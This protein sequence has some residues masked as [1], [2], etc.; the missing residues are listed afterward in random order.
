M[1]NQR[2]AGALNDAMTRILVLGGTTEAREFAGLLADRAD[3]VP[4]LSLAGRTRNPAVQ[5]VPTRVGGFGGTDGL[6]AF[7]RDENIGVLV[8]ATH[9]YA[10]R[11][12]A[13]AAAAARTANIAI[14]AIRRPG[15]Q[16]QEGDCWLRVPSV[17]DAVV[18]L[19]PDPRRVFLALGRN[20]VRAFD[21]APHHFYL[22]RSVDP[23]DPPLVLD[24]VRYLT[25]RGPFD[26]GAELRL[27]DEYE[28]DII[29]AKDSGGSA[30]Y[31]K[32]AAARVRHRPIVLI[33]RPAK[34][35]VPSAADA[36]AAMLLLDHVLG[37][38]R[39]RGV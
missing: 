34:P 30:T 11:I 20:E 4:I 12:S 19:G 3:I 39:K 32:I 13:N 6:A 36:E 16:H 31:A 29:V 14:M 25:A 1:D 37:S 21:A 24:R 7:L 33:D 27:I 9:P 8:D 23:V 18:A 2:V 38:L 28:I 17:G 10:A 5:P 26:E 22:V 35:S 15:W